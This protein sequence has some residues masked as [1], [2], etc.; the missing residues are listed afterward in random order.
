MLRDAGY[1]ASTAAQPHKSEAVKTAVQPIKPNIIRPN[2][3]IK[4]SITKPNSQSGPVHTGYIHNVITAKAGDTW[5]SIVRPFYD[6]HTPMPFKDFVG[7]QR[8]TNQLMGNVPD[9]G[10]LK[11]GT[12]V[13]IY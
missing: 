13:V 10:P 7:T 2:Q 8:A 6:N 11:P 12:R 3:P 4:P 1:S 9:K 5:E